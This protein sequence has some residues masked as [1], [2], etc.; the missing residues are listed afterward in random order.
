MNPPRGAG[1]GRSRVYSERLLRSKPASVEELEKFVFLNAKSL[2][3]SQAYYSPSK[4]TYGTLYHQQLGAQQLGAQQLGAQH[5]GAQQ[6]G[7]QQQ[8]LPVV[9]YYQ[10]QQRHPQHHQPTLSF[11]SAQ[12]H[13][14][15]AQHFR[16]VHPQK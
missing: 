13:Q 4:Q 11:N 12:A 10:P 5:L 1:T 2:C 14:L 7:A 8:V 3:V 15:H 9:Q 16:S 6:L